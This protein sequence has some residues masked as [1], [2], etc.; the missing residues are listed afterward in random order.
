MSYQSVYLLY[1]ASLLFASVCSLLRFRGLDTAARILCVLV[2]CAFLNEGAAYYAAKRYHNNLPVYA[3][4]CL[5]EFG[6]LAVY[7]NYVIDVFARRNIGIY[8]GIAGIVLGAVNVAFLQDLN[9]LNSNFLFFESIAVI[10]LCL[11]AFFRLLLKHDSLHFYLYHHFWFMS[12]LVFFWTITFLTWG[13]YDY[14]N[15]E[16]KREAWKINIGLMLVG[17]ITYTCFAVVF[18]LYPKMRNIHE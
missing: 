3:V 15:L 14:I 8:I 13:L 7:F 16:L 12:I 1:C 18:L 4:Y 6:I 5:I 10:G 9:S 2:C 17:T 11:F